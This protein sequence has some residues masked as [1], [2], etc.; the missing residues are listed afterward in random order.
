MIVVSPHLDDAVFSAGQTIAANPGTTVATV[1]AGIPPEGSLSPYDE[2]AGFATSADAVRAR[3]AEDDRAMVLLDSRNAHG[4]WLDGQ[5]ELDIDATAAIGWLHDVIATTTGP[6][7]IPLGLQHPDHEITH[8]LA[9]EAAN[10]RQV[11]LYEEL[12]YRIQYPEIVAARLAALPVE[13]IDLGAG[14]IDLKRAAVECYRSQMNPFMRRTVF[15]PERL[16]V[17]R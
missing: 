12:P 11:V 13:P 6:V 17:L 10:D 8:R 15:V 4:P 9:V 3:R 14:D 5:Y 16:W 1:F 2:S 7:L